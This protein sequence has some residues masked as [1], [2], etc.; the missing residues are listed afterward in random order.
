MGDKGYY[1]WDTTNNNNNNNN[2]NN[3]DNSNERSTQKAQPSILLSVTFT[4]QAKEASALRVL[5]GGSQSAF[6]R[7]ALEGRFC[8][9]AKSTVSEKKFLVSMVAK[10][11]LNVLKK[12]C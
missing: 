5:I 7:L 9:T 6:F 2:S 3:N 12:G 8:R 4:R 10:N 11:S 1:I